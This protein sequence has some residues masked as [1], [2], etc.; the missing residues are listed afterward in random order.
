MWLFLLQKQFYSSLAHSTLQSNEYVGY[1]CADQGKT[2]LKPFVFK[3]IG[4]GRFHR[5]YSK[6]VVLICSQL[7]ERL[8]WGLI[9]KRAI[10]VQSIYQIT[11]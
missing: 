5:K 10:K 8:H 3:H 4:L 1:H 7:T 6:L 2:A 9:Q 11:R